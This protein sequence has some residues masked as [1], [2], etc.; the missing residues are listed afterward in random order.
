MATG[1]GAGILVDAFVVRTLLV[2]ALVALFGRWNWWLP[3]PL[4]RLL[5][6]EPSDAVS[7]RV[8]TEP[9]TIPAQPAPRITTR[10]SHSA[11]G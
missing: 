9:V 10:G 3:A 5:R 11:R 4:A 7:E 6:V 1:L 8:A 2:P